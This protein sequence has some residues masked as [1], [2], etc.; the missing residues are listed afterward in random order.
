MNFKFFKFFNK[1]KECKNDEYCPIYLSY[2]GKYGDNSKEIKFCKNP[3]TQ[4]CTKYKLINQSKWQKM[5]KE[6]KLKL[7]KN[8]DLLN[9]IIKK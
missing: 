7:L 4:Y 2:L 9:F 1:N 3:D 6:E 5:T 8:I